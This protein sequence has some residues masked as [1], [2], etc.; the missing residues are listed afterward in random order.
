MLLVPSPCPVPRGP[1]YEEEYGLEYITLRK[2]SAVV[3]AAL[4]VVAYLSSRAAG[5]GRVTSTLCAWLVG[6]E[7]LVL[8]QSRL[9]LCDIF[10]YVTACPVGGLLPQCGLRVGRSLLGP[11]WAV[12]PRPLRT[13]RRV[14]GATSRGMLGIAEYSLSVRVGAA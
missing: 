14:M 5:C 9:I 7:A 11:I 12:G 6:V 4:I 13:R 10:L 2:V 1:R 3:G 8:L